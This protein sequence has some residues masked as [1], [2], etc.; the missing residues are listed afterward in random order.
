M[1]HI[2]KKIYVFV[3]PLVIATLNQIEIFYEEPK[4][5]AAYWFY[6]V[7]VLLT[8]Q[9]GIFH[10]LTC[11]SRFFWLGPSSLLEERSEIPIVLLF[12]LCC[13]LPPELGEM[14]KVYR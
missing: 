2:E 12:L 11:G 9:V 3:F 8:H 14:A 6:M 1:K 13:R 5:A 7:R 10:T 4:K